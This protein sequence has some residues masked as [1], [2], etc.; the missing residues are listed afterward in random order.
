MAI[1]NLRTGNFVNPAKNYYSAPAQT[2]EDGT[3][4]GHSHVV[5]ERLASKDQITP[6]DPRQ[7]AFFKGLNL[8]DINGVLTAD[9]TAGLPA[10][11]YRMASINSAANHQPALSAVAQRGSNDDISY[12]TVV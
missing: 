8:P 11:E 4:I 5:I 7:F 1:R 9:V 12:F 6:T 3:L 10:G 2:T